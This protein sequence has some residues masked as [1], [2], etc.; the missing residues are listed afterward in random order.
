MPQWAQF[1]GQLFFGCKL[2]IYFLSLMNFLKKHEKMFEEAVCTVCHTNVIPAFNTVHPRLTFLHHLAV[3]LRVCWASPNFPG[4][5]L[6]LSSSVHGS[7]EKNKGGC[8]SL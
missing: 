1:F 2:K 5:L 6:M 8:F 7:C 4:C 3:P